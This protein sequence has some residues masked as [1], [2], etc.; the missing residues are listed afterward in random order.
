MAIY[1]AEFG[2]SASDG[3]KGVLKIKSLRLCPVV[4]QAIKLSDQSPT[5]GGG[6]P[7]I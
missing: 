4:C 3:K 2:S 7:G 5:D 6:T 1:S